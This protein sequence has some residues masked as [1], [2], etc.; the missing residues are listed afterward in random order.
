MPPDNVALACLGDYMKK[1]SKLWFPF[2]SF[3]LQ[4]TH[5]NTFFKSAMW[6]IHKN[7]QSAGQNDMCEVCRKKKKYE[8]NGVKHPYCS[9]SCARAHATQSVI[10]PRC[11]TRGCRGTAVPAYGGFCTEAH[12]GDAVRRGQAPGC[13]QCKT[14]I[15]CVGPL[16]PGCDKVNRTGPRLREIDATSTTFKSFVSQFGDEWKGNRPIPSIERIIEV[17]LPWSVT[18]H[19]NAYRTALDATAYLRDLRTYYA[20]Q[21]MCDMG[22]YDLKFCE[23]DSCGICKVLKSSFRQLA[24]GAQYDSGRYGNGIYTCLNPALADEHATSS[25]TSPYRAMVACDVSIASES[26]SDQINDGFRVF[27]TKVEAILPR[28]VILYK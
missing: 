14:L 4:R 8:E 19:F 24:F 18:S 16:C 21:C 13:A 11:A 1:G 5:L 23:W 27:V 2:L 6:G 7:S 28:Y 10:V 22:V 25:S 3:H 26:S 17:V 9:R 20:D 15:A 12:A